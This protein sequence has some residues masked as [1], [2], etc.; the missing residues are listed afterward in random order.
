[1]RDQ[2]RDCIDAGLCRPV[3]LDGAVLQLTGLIGGLGIRVLSGLLTP[4]RMRT[5]VLHWIDG[6]LLLDPAPGDSIDTSPND[7]NTPDTPNTPDTTHTPDPSERTA[8]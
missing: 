2:I 4:Q 5:A 8:S 6:Q 1:M 3:V 7:T